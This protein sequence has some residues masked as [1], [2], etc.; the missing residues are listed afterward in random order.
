MTGKNN[1]NLRFSNVD[2][3][4]F[5]DRVVK[6]HTKYYQSDFEIDKEILHRA[7]YCPKQQ[8]KIFIWLCRTAGTWCL[9]ERNVFLKGTREHNTFNFYAEQSSEPVLAFVIEVTG[10]T[11]DSVMG[12]VYVLDYAAHHSHVLSVSL[13]AETAILNYEHGCRIQTA[14]ETISSCPDPEYGSLQSVQ[15]QPHSQKDLSK[16]LWQEHR[17]RRCFKTG[18]ADGYI[19]R[20]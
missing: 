5:M 3:L 1:D 11:A 6:K 13:N 20:L 2:I 9:H 17:E 12:N 15:Y 14:Y 16:I 8:D 18:E 19:E 10:T 7:A 4:G